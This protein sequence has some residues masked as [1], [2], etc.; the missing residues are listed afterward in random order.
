MKALITGATGFL[1]SALRRALEHNADEIVALGSSDCDLRRPDSLRPWDH[2]SFERIYHLATWTQA[3]DF[4]LR[5]PGEQWLVNQQINT[6]VLAWWQQRQPQARLI[7]I[8]SSCAYDPGLDLVEENYLAGTPTESLLAYAMTKRMLYV[9]LTALSKQFGL[10]SLFAVPA[11]LYGPG[12]HRPGRQSHFVFDVIRK[13]VRGKQYGEPV[14]LWG[15]GYQRRELIYVD[16]FVSV[17]LCLAG[18]DDVDLVNVGHGEDFSIRE[19][20]SLICRHVGYDFRN[21][22]F[23]TGRYVG[24]RAKCLRNDRLRRLLPDLRLT[25]LSAGLPRTID[26]TP[27]ERQE[28]EE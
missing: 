13:V 4:C 15:D 11:T 9:G 7:A 28:D 26:A 16:D 27:I 3:G 20:A 12:T 14:V 18:R 22:Q 21:V 1:G 25:P 17:L 19:F 5:H 8:G 24:A 2:H 10:R 23:D 6:N